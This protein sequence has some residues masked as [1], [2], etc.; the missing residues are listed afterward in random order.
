ME[1]PTLSA[2]FNT[3]LEPMPTVVSP[4][5]IEFLINDIIPQEWLDLLTKTWNYGIWI[6]QWEQHHR[7][8]TKCK[9][10][11][12]EIN[13]YN[14]IRARK[15]SE[16]QWEL[17]QPTTIKRRWDKTK[18]WDSN[19]V[20]DCP[21][22]IIPYKFL[23]VPPAWA[24]KAP[25][26]SN[27]TA[28]ELQKPFAKKRRPYLKDSSIPSVIIGDFVELVISAAWEAYQKGD[29]G[30]PRFKKDGDRVT[31]IPCKNFRSS[32]KVDGDRLKLPGLDW[33]IIP[34][35]Q[36]RV[37]MPIA[38]LAK[39]MKANPHE[40]PELVAKQEKLLQAERSRLLKEDGLN[41]KNLRK[42]LSEAEVQEILD[43][44]T[45]RID[46]QK[47]F[48]KA[49]EYYSSPGAFRLCQ[50]RGKTYL[51]ITGFF[52]TKTA[53]RSREIL[54]KTGLDL[55]ISASN[56]LVVKHQDFSKQDKR[57]S[58][59]DKVIS[60]CE[61]GS[62]AW[63]K[64]MAKKRKLEARVADSKRLRQVFYAS[65]ISKTNNKI[66][67]EKITIKDKIGLPIPKP[68]GKGN[69]LPNGAGKAHEKNKLIHDVALG[70][71][72]LLCKQQ[73]KR[74]GRIYSE[75]STELEAPGTTGS[76]DN[77]PSNDENRE[78]VG[79]RPNTSGKDSNIRLLA[80]Q[81]ARVK[82]PKKPTKVAT[83]RRN[84]KREKMI[85]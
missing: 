39:S 33:I 18:S 49:I 56:G 20:Y 38:A 15:N 4:R 10:Q 8:M 17:Y 63:Q 25:G 45:L 60:R 54:V 82:E 9:E 11:G 73:A 32:C 3:E 61:H 36:Q 74:R 64:L 71:F 12:I 70:Q 83:P 26:I 67:V 50:K 55:M 24:E 29:R 31:T 53:A 76:E 58:N 23:S 44:Y 72:V 84:R 66:I 68:D 21:V 30:K 1:L 62:K 35:L 75:I 42:E 59:L 13:P 34:G 28:F 27:S 52:P 65:K 81:P 85:G 51:Q 43:D 47:L 41:L 78:M 57:L 19:N 77:S 40:Y 48:D 22:N 7:R 37:M 14:E 46:Q 16:G 2:C 79:D 5:T 69:Y 6:L 80:V